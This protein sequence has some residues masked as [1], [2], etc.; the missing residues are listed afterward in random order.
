MQR[1]SG[2]VNGASRHSARALPDS[3]QDVWTKNVQEHD[4]F[5]EALDATW[6]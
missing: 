2:E 1:F 5:S 3:L 4:T 6:F